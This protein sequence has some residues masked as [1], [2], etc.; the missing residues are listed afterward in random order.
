MKGWIRNLVPFCGAL[1]TELGAVEEEE[2]LGLSFLAGCGGW[3]LSESLMAREVRVPGRRT[4]GPVRLEAQF[5]F[6]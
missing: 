2:P 6:L 3:R 5:S 1:G 4:P